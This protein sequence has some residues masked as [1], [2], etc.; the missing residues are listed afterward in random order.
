MMHCCTNA[1]QHHM[2]KVCIHGNFRMPYF[3]G[4]Q[5]AVE[6]QV[7]VIMPPALQHHAAQTLHNVTNV[8]QLIAARTL[9]AC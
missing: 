9:E 8:L 6:G 3:Q 7:G 4:L 1:L 5:W 2:R